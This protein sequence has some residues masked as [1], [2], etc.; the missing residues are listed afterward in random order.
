VRS[1][2]LLSVALLAAC[3]HGRE[4]WGDDEDQ[5]TRPAPKPAAKADK[6]AKSDTSGPPVSFVVTSNDEGEGTGDAL[7]KVKHDPTVAKPP[8]EK[9]APADSGPVVSNRKPKE[10]PVIVEKA[11]PE[12]TKLKTEDDW[13]TSTE[14][15]PSRSSDA[16]KA[17]K[18]D[19]SE[20]VAIEQHR[21]DPF[22]R[23]DNDLERAED[24]ASSSAAKSAPKPSVA[25]VEEEE[26]EPEPPPP[27]KKKRDPRRIGLSIVVGAGA[28][29]NEGLVPEYAAHLAYGGQVT[30]NP[31]FAGD[32]AL[33]VGFWRSGNK[34]STGFSSV[35]SAD[36]YTSLRVMYLPT[37]VAGFYLGVGVGGIATFR[38]VHYKLGTDLPSEADAAAFRFGGDG[39]VAFGY[40]WKFLEARI[41]LRTMIHQ[42]Y[43][44]E[45][46]PTGAIGA[47]F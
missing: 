42:G 2:I 37:I 25:S 23:L 18:G 28:L 45:F 19:S 22:K 38:Q 31:A 9:A 13:A 20:A 26:R 7:D 24:R 43:R 17:K 11:T 6:D 1:I 4:H 5:S 21:E 44:L 41:D 39:T 32:F 12:K 16:P 46:L 40:R 15:K 3:A 10:I 30:W 8:A 47:T 35:E 14:S 33:D 34:T 29:L 36:N 27:P